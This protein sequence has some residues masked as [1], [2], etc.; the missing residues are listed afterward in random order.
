MTGAPKSRPQGAGLA[1]MAA[2][3]LLGFSGGQAS[4]QHI[5]ERFPSSGSAPASIVESVL[6]PPGA[7]MLILSGQTASRADAPDR[8]VSV[9]LPPAALGDTKTQTINILSKIRAALGRRGYALADVVKLTVYLVGDPANGGRMDYAGMNEGYRQF[10]GASQNPNLVARATVQVV[11]LA[12]PA[13]LV[14]IEAT[15]VRMP[16]NR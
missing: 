15:A 16:A 1:M 8:P 10:F 4:A 5:I 3:T 11:A 7:E 2:V 6:V 9:D 12:E 13:F 14:E